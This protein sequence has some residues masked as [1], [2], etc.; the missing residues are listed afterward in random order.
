MG[1]FVVV[2]FDDILVYSQTEKEHLDHLQKVLKALTENDLFVNLKDCTFLTNK[3]L[4]LGYIVSSKEI[5]VNEDKVKAVRDW[6][7]PKILTKGVFMDLRI[8]IEDL[9]NILVV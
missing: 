1:K 2:Y 3:L 4:F 6:L 8:F 9:C 5:H 7:S